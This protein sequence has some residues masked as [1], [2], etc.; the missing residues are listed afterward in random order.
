MPPEVEHLLAGCKTVAAK[1]RALDTAGY[2]RAEIARI[3][4]KRYQHVRNVLEEPGKPEAREMPGMAE[5]DTT[6]FVQDRQRT[7]R[8]PVR[9]DGAVLLPREVLTALGSKPGGVLIADLDEEGLRVVGAMA[10]LRQIQA[11][12]RE[13][14]PADVSLAD[15]LISD[16]RQE[17]AEDAD[18]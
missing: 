9:E 17:V 6:N 14:V 18:A 2:P 12:V 10:A 8:L 5:A 7:Y 13:R 1:I 15:E 16:R 4:G 3:L 11:I